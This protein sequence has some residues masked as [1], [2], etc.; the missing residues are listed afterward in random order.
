LRFFDFVN[1]L[2]LSM[3]LEFFAQFLHISGLFEEISK[4][5][6]S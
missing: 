2:I 4:S 6:F 1:A 3:L 5:E